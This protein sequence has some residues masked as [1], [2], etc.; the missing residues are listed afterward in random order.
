MKGQ[1]NNDSTLERSTP[2]PTESPGAAMKSESAGKA[3]P[4]GHHTLSTRFTSGG[5]NP[6]KGSKG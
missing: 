4:R 5:S 1:R 6:G 2:I 3:K